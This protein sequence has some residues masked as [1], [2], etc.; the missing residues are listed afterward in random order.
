MST[1]KRKIIPTRVDSVAPPV[2]AS[3][4]D[5]V[6][7]SRTPP[8]K[9]SSAWAPK[10]HPAEFEVP[11][12]DTASKDTEAY[13]A[14][15]KG[16]AETARL[17][18][19][20]QKAQD[21]I[22]KRCAKSR[23]AHNDVKFV[24]VSALEAEWRQSNAHKVAFGRH[25]RAMMRGLEKGLKQVHDDPAG[26]PRSLNKYVMAAVGQSRED[27]A[28]WAGMSAADRRELEEFV[29]ADSFEGEGALLLAAQATQATR[30]D[31]E[32]EEEVSQDEH[33]ASEAEEGEEEEVAEAD[34]MEDAMH[35]AAVGAL[36]GPPPPS[37]A[38]KRKRTEGAT[39]GVWTQ[40][41]LDLMDAFVLR[42]AGESKMAQEDY[43]Q[44]LK[45]RQTGIYTELQEIIDWRTLD[46][47]HSKFV[48]RYGLKKKNK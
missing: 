3:L 7:R 8:S 23:N 38:T 13:K 26:A 19:R 39:T 10:P 5:A 36:R 45:G 9:S 25:H 47:V 18:R 21:R 43:L 34:W 29:V 48:K 42:K 24:D 22:Y 31:E 40:Q 17:A 16:I 35:M 44:T 15:R 27:A 11:W 32:E 6:L 41:E 2:T 12:D 37:W 4:N 20:E 1:T 14:S 33:S 30:R 46:A 28:E